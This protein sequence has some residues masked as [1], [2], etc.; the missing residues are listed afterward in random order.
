ME[1]HIFCLKNYT[2]GKWG[3]RE[4][5][6]QKSL[7]QLF[8]GDRRIVHCDF[9]MAIS[10]LSHTLSI[11]G[12]LVHIHLSLWEYITG[13]FYDSYPRKRVLITNISI[14]GLVRETR[15]DMNRKGQIPTSLLLP[16]LPFLIIS[17]TTIHRQTRTDKDRQGQTRTQRINTNSHLLAP[18][19]PPPPL[20]PSSPTSASSFVLLR[21][22]LASYSSL[23]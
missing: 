21:T 19:S 14:Q 4:A 11:W 18:P 12:E 8:N 3:L 9:I 16:L 20:L 2:L 17:Q 1:C 13:C 6:N 10:W 22:A 23:G 15:I 7:M 5:F